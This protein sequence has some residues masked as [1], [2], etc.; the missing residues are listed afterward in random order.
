VVTGLAASM[1]PGKAVVST[2]KMGKTC[3]IKSGGAMSI[4]D[5]KTCGLLWRER[6]ELGPEARVPVAW[7]QPQATACTELRCSEDFAVKLEGSCRSG[8]DEIGA[9][10]ALGYIVAGAKGAV[11]EKKG[12]GYRLVQGEANYLRPPEDSKQE[13]KP[14]A[15]Q[16][17]PPTGKITSGS[18]TCKLGGK[19][20]TRQQNAEWIGT[21]GGWK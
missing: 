7:A 13:K 4:S 5:G 14:A 10:A 8:A 1:D 9:D 3:T 11:L 21:E 12:S 18:A 16:P 19:P 15:A 20:Q 6:L 2:D 17:K